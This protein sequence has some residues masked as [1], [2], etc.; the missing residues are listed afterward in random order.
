[1]PDQKREAVSARD[2]IAFEERDRG[3][4]V[5][6]SADTRSCGPRTY[7]KGNHNFQLLLSCARPLHHDDNIVFHF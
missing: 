5:D 6:S 1:M 7:E 2:L 3:G 4:S